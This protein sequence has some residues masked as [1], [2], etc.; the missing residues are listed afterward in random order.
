MKTSYVFIFLS[1][2]GTGEAFYHAWTENAFVT[3]WASVSFAPFASFFGVPYWVFG[4][5][6]FPLVFAVGLWQTRLGKQPLGWKFLFFLSIGNV[7]TAYLWFV[8]LVVVSAFSP[9][10]VGL[11]VTNY[12]LTG[13]VVAQNWPRPVV[14]DFTL[15]T[16]V[17]LVLGVFFGAFGAAL[18]GIGGGIFGAVGGYTSE[19]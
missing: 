4:I 17:G 18:L 7:F 5:V 9:A 3:N 19:K 11:Y 10:Y 2:V 12:A 13:A 1:L 16:V 14:R 8:D 15:G 6:W